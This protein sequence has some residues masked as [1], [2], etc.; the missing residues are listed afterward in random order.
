MTKTNE[1]KASWKHK[2]FL[3]MT[4]YWINVCYL[5]ILFAVFTSYRRLILANYDISYSNWGISLIKALV[6][7]KVIMIGGLF[8]FRSLENKPLIF[9]TLFKSVIFTFWVVLFALGES[10]IR[11]FLH[12]KGLAGAL[13]HLLSEGTDEF[14]AKCL[15]VFVAFIPFFAFKELGRVLGKGKIWGLFFRKGP[16]AEASLGKSKN[17]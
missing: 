15:V 6:L 1:E 17:D 11:G 9:P 14:F 12:G 5:T 13:D 3:E 10:A 4:A 8:H 16:V 7:A 2:L